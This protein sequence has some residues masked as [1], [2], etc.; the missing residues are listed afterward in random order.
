MSRYL[1]IGV[2]LMNHLI[3]AKKSAFSSP[4]STQITLAFRQTSFWSKALLWTVMGVSSFGLGW[5]CVAQIEQ[6][7]PV[8]GQ[9]KPEGKVKEVQTPVGGVITQVHVEDG[10]RVQP[11]DLL[12]TFDTTNTVARLK[13]L[14]EEKQSLGQEN[15]YYQALMQNAA[16]IPR[17]L[18]PN[19]PLEIAQLGRERAELVTENQVFRAKLSG[20]IPNVNGENL[21]RLNALRAQSNAR[22]QTARLDMAQLEKRL[23]QNQVQLADAKKQLATEKQNLVDIQRR[24]QSGLKNTQQSLQT[25]EQILNRIEPLKEEGAIALIQYDKQLQAVNELRA[26]LS[27]REAEASLDMNQQRQTIQSTQADIDRLIQE[28]KRLQLELSQSQ[29]KLNNIMADGETNLRGQIAANE[30]RLAEIYSQL[31]KRI[32]ENKKR[33]SQIESELS[34]TKLNLTYQ[35]LKADTSG[36]VFDLKASQPGFVAKASQP[37][38]KIVPQDFLIAEVFITNQDIGFVKEGM[39]VDVRIDSFNFSEY[40]DIQGKIISIGK[41]ALEPDEIYPFY[42]FPALIRLETQNLSVNGRELSLQSG[43]S[44]SANVIVNE[45]RR[46]IS[47]VAESLVKKLDALKSVD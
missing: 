8:T 31:T 44:I 30:Q 19:L 37:L 38:L 14:N 24:D 23:Q 47:L 40:G 2:N 27:Q 33:L 6:T 46:V 17:H 3:R 12:V 32:V 45:K 15:Q 42:R 5:A 7:V 34:Q 20:D 36:V 11:G 25:E 4:E 18:P 41:D 39:P 21:A 43:M 13:S 35:N 1:L 29:Q 10:E 16:S 28:Q 22:I 9:L 26:E